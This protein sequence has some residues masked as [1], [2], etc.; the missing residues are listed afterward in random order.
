[1]DYDIDPS[2]A[3]YGI[4]AFLGALTVIYFGS[5]LIFDLS[6]VTKALA[7][8]SSFA[9]FLTASLYLSGE[10]RIQSMLSLGLAGVSYLAF[11]AYTLGKFE[12][13]AEGVFTSLLLSSMLFLVLGYLASHERLEIGKKH[14]KYF[15]AV[16]LV[17]G[18]ALILIDV[19]GAQPSYSV[20]LQDSVTFGPGDDVVFGTLTV[21][22]SFFLPREVSAPSFRSCIGLEESERGFYVDVD[23]DDVVS[24]LS[25]K[26]YNLSVGLP[27]RRFI[28]NSRTFQ[29][30]RTDS[31]PEQRDNETIYVFQHDQARTVG[32]ID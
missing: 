3:M 13:G 29:V 17:C 4:A 5:S 1:M 18:G 23:T 11:L 24:G 25:E 31:C 2:T 30:Q 32:Y 28:N 10:N 22:N 27:S 15:L 19:F 26:D 9:V 20:G 21:S 16:I 7:F 6:P 14:M 12:V 8:F